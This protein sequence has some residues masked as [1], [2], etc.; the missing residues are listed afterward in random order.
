MVAMQPLVSR[1]L[2]V[3]HFFG[4]EMWAPVPLPACCFSSGEDDLS[5]RNSL[6]STVTSINGYWARTFWG[7]GW[8]EF[9][10]RRGSTQ[11]SEGTFKEKVLVIP[12]ITFMAFL[13]TSLLPMTTVSGPAMLQKLRRCNVP[14]TGTVDTAKS[15]KKR[16]SLE[17][18]QRPLNCT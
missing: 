7:L 11:E 14:E 4:H 8:M 6:S 9:F 5:A 3:L 16:T 15:C 12:G 2:P 18:L 1:G 10:P 13:A 17:L